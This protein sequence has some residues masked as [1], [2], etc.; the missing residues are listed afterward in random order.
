VAQSHREEPCG[1]IQRSRVIARLMA[2]NPAK[3]KPLPFAMWMYIGCL[4]RPGTA[5]HSQRPLAGIA[6]LALATA[7]RKFG[8]SNSVSHLALIGGGC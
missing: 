1:V 7:P 8:H 6:H 5:R 2:Y 3:E 4:R